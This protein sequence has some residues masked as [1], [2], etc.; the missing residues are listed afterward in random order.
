MLCSGLGFFVFDSCTRSATAGS[1]AASAAVTW[2]SIWTLSV[3][4]LELSRFNSSR[5]SEE[6]MTAD[7]AM[8]RTTITSSRVVAALAA[9]RA[10]MERRLAP[11]RAR[12][13]V[14]LPAARTIST[15]T[16]DGR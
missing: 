14:R 16:T 8:A 3:V 11:S 10:A 12:P 13:I 2:D 15:A 1:D 9:T 7:R 5:W 4:A 6:L